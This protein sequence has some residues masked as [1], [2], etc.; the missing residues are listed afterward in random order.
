MLVVK[1]IPRTKDEDTDNLIINLGNHLNTE[2]Q[3]KDIDISHR[4]SNDAN[5][6]IIVKFDSRR[7]RDRF[8]LGRKQLKERGTTAKDIGF[9]INNKI[10]IN[11]SLTSK[12]G[13]LFKYTRGK[14]TKTNRFKFAWT[15]NGTVKVRKDDSSNSKIITINSKEKVL[16][17]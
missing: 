11:E 1:R 9:N 7:A 16:R 6:D 14:L 10:Y 8:Y 4:T 2:T 5:A 13:D 3:T 17:Q 15:T 12:N